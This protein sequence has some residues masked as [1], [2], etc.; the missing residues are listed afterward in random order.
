MCMILLPAVLGEGLMLT[1]RYYEVEG[2]TD[3][4]MMKHYENLAF[5][6][7]VSGLILTGMTL[8]V[9]QTSFKGLPDPATGAF[10]DTIK[11]DSDFW[12]CFIL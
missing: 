4:K 12:S 9:Y 2:Y 11:Y 8:F 10:A 5:A 1:M 7:A 6:K 3:L